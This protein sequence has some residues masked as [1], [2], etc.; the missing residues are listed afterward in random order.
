MKSHLSASMRR[1][2]IGLSLRVRALRRSLRALVLSFAAGCFAVFSLPLPAAR[3]VLLIGVCLCDWLVTEIFASLQPVNKIVIQ[4]S[5]T[6]YLCNTILYYFLS[7]SLLF[8]INNLSKIQPVINK[9]KAMFA[10]TMDMETLKTRIIPELFRRPAD[11]GTYGASPA[12]G[13]NIDRLSELLE[14]GS[15]SKLAARIEEIVRDLIAAD[16]QTIARKP[17]AFARFMGKDLEQELLYRH[18]R[19]HLDEKIESTADLVAHLRAVLHQMSEIESSLEAESNHLRLCIDAGK[20]YLTENPQ[21]GIPDSDLEYDRPRER[22]AR[23]LTNLAA[24]LA[25]HEMSIQQIRLAKA[26]AIDMLDRYHEIITTLLPV[27]RQHTLALITTRHMSAELISK[28][29]QAHAALMDSLQKS[30][31]GIR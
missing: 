3:E 14:Q 11:I 21:A 5:I 23:K 27:W 8:A 20:A 24:L 15:A 17:S 12:P 6:K 31:D 19:K 18:A 1:L 29:T 25:S 10:N 2:R 26:Q 16:P 7:P 22:F 30:L 13:K 9:E 4:K 28:A